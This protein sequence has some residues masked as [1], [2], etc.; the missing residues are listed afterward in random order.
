MIRAYFMSARK[1]DPAAEAELTVTN[2]GDFAT[3]GIAEQVAGRLLDEAL[4]YF[5][6]A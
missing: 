3:W 6:A 5:Q 4:E 2:L 1:P